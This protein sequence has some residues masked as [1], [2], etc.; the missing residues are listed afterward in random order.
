MKKNKKYLYIPIE[1]YKRELSGML[2]LAVAAVHEGYDVII[3]GKKNIFPYMNIFPEGLFFLKSIVPGELENL[4]KIK[5]SGHKAASLDAEGLI[6]TKGKIGATLRYSEETIRRTD[7]IFFW[8]EKQYERAKE[9]FPSLQKKSYVT[10]SPVFD[11]WRYE[12]KYVAASCLKKLSKNIIIATGFPFPNHIISEDMARKLLIDTLKKGTESSEFI[13]DFLK[14]GDLQRAVLPHFKSAMS[15]LFDAL[16]DFNFTIRPHIA[17]SSKIW[18]EL[19]KEYDNVNVCGK[20]SF[21]SIIKN[22]DTLIHFNSTTS[23]EASYLGKKVITYIPRD[24]VSPELINLLNE[25][26]LSVSIICDN[27]SE[28]IQSIKE[29]LPSEKNGSESIEQSIFGYNNME[30]FLSSIKIVQ[31]LKGISSPNITRKLP[32]FLTLNLSPY[33]LKRGLWQRMLWVLGWIDFFTNIFS[34]KYASNK[35]YYSY[36]KT[37]QGKIDINEVSDYIEELRKEISPGENVKI[38]Q[39]K[40]GLL[41]LTRPARQK[42]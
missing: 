41:H 21:S 1:I 30:P 18:I 34:G 13:N 10:G 27:E 15:K 17:E 3:G 40:N 22:N 39:I 29:N 31:H 12:K 26:A 42:D 36:G 9:Y 8:G 32:N 7:K 20:G 6:L 37:K 38:K 16:P 23:I 5:A 35:D 4:N 2:I 14:M 28:L 19:A 33:A 11:F 25:D 24:K